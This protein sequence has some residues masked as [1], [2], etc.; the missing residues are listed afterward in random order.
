VSFLG[1]EG[2]YDALAF[3]S[4]FLHIF[5]SVFY[6]FAT[7]SPFV[8]PLS[9]MAY[10]NGLFSAFSFIGFLLCLIPL[11]WHLEGKFR[12]TLASTHNRLTTLAPL[13]WNVGT[14]LFMAWAGLGCL[15]AFINSVVWNSSVANVAPVWCDICLLH[16]VLSVPSAVT[17]S[18]DFALVIA[19]RFMIGLN[20]G[21][22]AALLVINRRLYKIASRTATISTKDDKRRANYVDLAIGL[23][24]PFLQ[25]VLGGS[26]L[27]SLRLLS[28]RIFRDHC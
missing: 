21:L 19:S 23:S 20:V 17:D 7:P 9:L 2:L 8:L 15:N 6:P 11:Y 22:P 3:I 25:M 16:F 28:D 24:I 4:L 27:V 5:H 13:A 18:C 26:T 14:S 10:P 12:P 1:G